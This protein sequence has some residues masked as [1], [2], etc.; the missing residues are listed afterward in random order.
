MSIF[1]KPVI[2]S[3][4]KKNTKR[5]NT[6]YRKTSPYFEPGHELCIKKKKEPWIPPKSPFDLIQEKLYE[7]PWQL[8]IATI[9]LNKTTGKVALPI[10]DEF[11]KKWPSP[12]AILECDEAELVELLRPCGTYH[13]RAKVIKRFTGNCQVVC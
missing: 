5:K 9:F 6:K 4:D 2:N 13:R 10:L 1:L 3:P 12:E 11:L 7:K 8:L